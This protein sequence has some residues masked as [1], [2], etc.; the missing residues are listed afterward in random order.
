MISPYTAKLCRNGSPP[1]PGSFFSLKI[2]YTKGPSNQIPSDL[3]A[4]STT[5]R[6]HLLFPGRSVFRVHRKDDSLPSSSSKN[7][8]EREMRSK[9]WHVV[10]SDGVS[11][12]ICSRSY[13]KTASAWSKRAV[14][15]PL[16]SRTVSLTAAEPPTQAYGEAIRPRV[17]ENAS[18]SVSD[19]N[20]REGGTEGALTLHTPIILVETWIVHVFDDCDTIR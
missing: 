5:D 14:G 15:G 20:I 2:R 3:T 11:A 12:S 1:S 16:R 10:V 7:T 19:E 17:R 6:C 13:C 4:P 18:R 8:V 9:A